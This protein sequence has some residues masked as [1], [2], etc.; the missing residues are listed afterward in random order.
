MRQGRVRAQPA[1]FFLP[2]HHER[3]SGRE[4]VRGWSRRTKQGW[5]C[6]LWMSGGCAGS[7]T[8][9]GRERMQGDHLYCEEGMR[10]GKERRSA[11]LGDCER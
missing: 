3:E 5:V 11:P 8:K 6:G 2:P 9:A 10:G 4:H 7:R 1:S